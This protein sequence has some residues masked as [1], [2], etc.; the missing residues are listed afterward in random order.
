MW[1][2]RTWYCPEAGSPSM[3]RR[4]GLHFDCLSP[5]LT[6]LRASFTSKTVG[7][8]HHIPE[9]RQTQEWS[10]ALTLAS[11]PWEP[12]V[13]IRVVYVYISSVAGNEEGRGR[14][15]C[16]LRPV[17]QHIFVELWRDQGRSLLLWILCVSR[18]FKIKRKRNSEKWFP[19]CCVTR[20]FREVWYRWLLLR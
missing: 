1:K 2:A 10:R 19:R 14:D 11:L 8:P 6:P 5:S 9:R 16:I 17:H 12:H 18:D 3:R 13:F 7:S 15:Q 4:F 20:A